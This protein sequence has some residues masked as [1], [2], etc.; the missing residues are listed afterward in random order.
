LKR[1]REG[2]KEKSGATRGRAKKEGVSL[3]GGSGGVPKYG[4]Y[5]RGVSEPSGW[6]RRGRKKRSSGCEHHECD[7][8][9]PGVKE[10]KNGF[11]NELR[12]GEKNR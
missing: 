12:K 1:R 11:F 7:I 6:A 3:T 4:D 8:V 2:G 9:A 10:R 5:Q